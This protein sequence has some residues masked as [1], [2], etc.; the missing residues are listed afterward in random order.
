MPRDR[1][2]VT[3]PCRVAGI[4][5][6]AA[7]LG[8]CGSWGSRDE[9]QSPRSPAT[10]G[11]ETHLRAI[12]S[13]VTGKARVIDRGDGVTLMLSMINLPL[14]VYRVS[15]NERA[16][17]T[18]P[19][20]FSAGAPWAPASTGKDPRNLVP[21]LTTNREGTAE[22][23]VHIRGLHTT[24]PDGVAGRSIVVYAGSEV[25]DARPDVPNNRIACGTFEA[26]VPFQF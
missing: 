25:T 13:G 20:G 5:L 12:H 19:N 16:N 9:A 17:C 11:L 26:V 21:V 4:V 3:A 24:G 15:F 2:D 18:S 6:A 22:A 10:P 7:V 14:G 1:R 8:G 23:S